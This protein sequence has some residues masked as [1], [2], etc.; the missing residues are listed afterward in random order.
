MG[1]FPPRTIALS[2]DPSAQSHLDWSHPVQ[3]SQQSALDTSSGRQAGALLF[4]LSGARVT[5][6]DSTRFKF[7]PCPSHIKWQG[8]RKLLLF[9]PEASVVHVWLTN[10]AYPVFTESPSESST[11][12]NYS[13]SHFQAWKL[14]PRKKEEIARHPQLVDPRTSSCLHS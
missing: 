13:S 1:G 3:G 7:S 12:A 14:R 5:E 2:C 8:C 11:E 6:T 4:L 10:R 9:T